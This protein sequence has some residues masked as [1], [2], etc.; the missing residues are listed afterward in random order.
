MCRLPR[1]RPR[2][3]DDQ[4]RGE[5]DVVNLRPQ[6]RDE[7]PQATFCTP[8]QVN[9]GRKCVTSL[10][11]VLHAELKPAGV[12]VIVLAPGGMKIEGSQNAGHNLSS[13]RQMNTEEVARIGLDASA[14]RVS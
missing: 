12:D 14:G 8:F 2:Q 6:M 9:D 13:V 4:P 5:P 7:R 3:H 11:T 10:G 1:L